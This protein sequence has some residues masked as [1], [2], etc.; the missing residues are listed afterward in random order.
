MVKVIK[1]KK[2]DYTNL[3]GLLK[4]AGLVNEETNQAYPEKI[5]ISKEDSKKFQKEIFK[6]FKKQYPYLTTRKLQA[7][8][9]MYWLN[10]GPSES[11]VEGVRPGYAIV[12]PLDQ[13]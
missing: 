13:E 10:L 2:N 5:L 8:A 1:L 4:R 6:A 3:S 9:G 7:S 12:L 11:A